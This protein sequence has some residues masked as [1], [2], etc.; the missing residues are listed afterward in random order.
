MNANYFS[1]LKAGSKPRYRQKLYIIGV[2]D[3][4]YRLPADIWCDIPCSGLKSNTL[5]SIPADKHVLKIS[6][7]HLK[8]S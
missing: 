6:S 5:I 7:G 8:R 3:C 4:Q 1:T 2:K